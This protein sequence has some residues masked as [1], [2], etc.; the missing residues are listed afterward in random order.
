M[1]RPSRLDALRV[2][3]TTHSAA[4]HEGLLRELA[5]AGYHIS[6]PTL[7]NDLKKLRAVRVRTR[8]GVHYALPTQQEYIRPVT[9]ALLP[10]FLQS[11]GLLSVAY[12]DPLLILHTHPGHAAAIAATI[13][14]QQFPTVAGTVAGYDT[15]FVARAAS[16]DLQ[17]LTD[18]L[19]TILPALKSVL[20]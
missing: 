9:A 3:L 2:I 12:T 14:A 16:A 19:A 15:L 11:G 1:K 4:T 18:E 7:S 17:Q 13:D 20:P 8:E 5:V 10:D 6:Q